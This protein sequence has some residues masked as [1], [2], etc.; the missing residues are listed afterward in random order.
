MT[1]YNKVNGQWCAENPFLLTRRC[2]RRWGFQGFV[3][4]D[5]GSTYSTAATVSAGMNLEMPGGE[6]MRR[7]FARARR[8]RRPGN[9]AG[10][11]A[12]DKVLA[13]LASGKLKQAAVDD[14]VRRMLRVMF[15]AGLFD[16]P[17][18]GRR[19]GG[20]AGAAGRGARGRDREHGPAE[21][22][23]AACCRWTPRK[24]ASI[25]VIGPSAAVARTGGGGSSLVRPKYTVTPLDGIKETAGAAVQVGYALG[26]AM[27]GEDKA[28]DAGAASSARRGRRAGPRSRTSPWCSSA[29]RSKLESEGF[30]RTRMDLPA[31]QDELI[32][33]VAAANREHGR[34]GG[35]RRAGR[36]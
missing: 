3:V 7:R 6:P 35:G 16:K 4:S 19:R 10:W 26:V 8:R 36:P 17:H 2:R 15:T 9:G 33:A 1:A 20:H 23:R 13:A 34:R 22:R 32:A 28:A 27:E 12:E 24:V 21:E 11:L 30:D 14:S 5:W 29:T 25:A 18:A 31:G